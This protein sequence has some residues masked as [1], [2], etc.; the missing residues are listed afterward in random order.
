M[1][2]HTLT[3]ISEDSA[4]AGA[5]VGGSTL[6]Q[7]ERV[8]VEVGKALEAMHQLTAERKAKEAAQAAQ[9]EA[10]AQAKAMERGDDPATRAGE[11]PR[12]KIPTR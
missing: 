4:A 8:E 3:T 5:G 1:A 9:A 6:R 11:P 2:Q 7:I 10:K 12:A